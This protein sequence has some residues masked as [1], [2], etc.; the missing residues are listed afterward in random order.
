MNAALLAAAEG[1]WTEASARFRVVLEEDAAN[2]V[3]CP[4]RVFSTVYCV[5]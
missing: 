5:D 1:D 3:V 4:P 2:Y